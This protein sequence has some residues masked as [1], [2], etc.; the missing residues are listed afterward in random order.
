MHAEHAAF[1]PGGIRSAWKGQGR[2]MKKHE[3][4]S[5]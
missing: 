2:M 5:Q 4:T 3:K 1:G